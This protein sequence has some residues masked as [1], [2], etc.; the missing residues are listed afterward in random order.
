VLLPGVHNAMSA[1]IAERAGASAVYLSGS[2]VS[3]ALLGLP[4]IGLM[5]GA[6]MIDEARRVV[7]ATSLPVICDADTGYGNAVNVLRTVRLYEATGVAGIQIEDQ[8]FPKRCGHFDGKDLI[9]TEEMVGKIRAAIEARQDPDFVLIARTDAIEGFGLEAAIE[10]GLAYADAG[11]DIVFVEAPQGEADLRRIASAIPAPLIVNVVE[12]GKTPQ[13]SLDVYAAMGFRIVL[14][15]TTN[16]R[17]AA[18]A[19]DEF[20]RYLLRSGSS[21]GFERGLLGFDERNAVNELATYQDWEERFA[22]TQEEII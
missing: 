21:S 7:A 8:T 1:R 6:E 22:P 4:D 10:R 18:R 16:V 2:G 3:M 11:A 9:S 19:L 12:G 20:Y 5:T 15:P 13:L 14:Y 17:V